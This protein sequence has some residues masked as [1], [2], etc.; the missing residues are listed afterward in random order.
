MPFC[1]GTTAFRPFNSG[2]ILWLQYSMFLVKNIGFLLFQENLTFSKDL[3][4]HSGG[5][6]E[7]NK[8]FL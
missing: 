4:G 3:S 7:N 6:I 8:A 5:T 2:I 1:A